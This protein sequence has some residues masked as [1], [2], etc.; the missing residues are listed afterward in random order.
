[1]V[2]YGL[3]F[4]NGDK[5]RTYILILDNVVFKKFSFPDGIKDGIALKLEGKWEIY[6]L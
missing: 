4:I 5:K 6:Q 1:M 2:G 3:F